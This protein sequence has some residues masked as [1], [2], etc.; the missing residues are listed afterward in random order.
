M[1]TDSSEQLLTDPERTPTA[2]HL[3]AE[4]GALYPIYA[5]LIDTIEADGFCLAAEWRFYKDGKAW[6]CKISRKKKTVVW[7][8]A[9]RNCLRLGFYFTARKGMGIPE[10]DID[11]VLKASYAAAKPIGKLKPLVVDLKEFEQLS[12]LYTL[13]RYKISNL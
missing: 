2:E 8:S 1:S 4:F 5:E 11:P 7:M 12:D 6:L 13:L 9:W 10:L 3:K